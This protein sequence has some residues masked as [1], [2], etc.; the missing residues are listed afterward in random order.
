[1]PFTTIFFLATY[2]GEA[3]LFRFEPTWAPHTGYIIEFPSA[4]FHDA[5]YV[6]VTFTS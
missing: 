1:M 6:T 3:N 2:D 5:E 4:E